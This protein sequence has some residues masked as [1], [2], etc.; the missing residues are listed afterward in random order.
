MIYSVKY[1]YPGK[2]LELENCNVE[3]TG[4]IIQIIAIGF[5][6]QSCGRNPNGRNQSNE[7]WLH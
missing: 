6:M 5:T 2:V 1:V 4:V 3:T 7:H